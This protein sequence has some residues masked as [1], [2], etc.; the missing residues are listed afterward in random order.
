MASVLGN[1]VSVL[2]TDPELALNLLFCSKDGLKLVPGKEMTIHSEIFFH[3]A[4]TFLFL[5]FI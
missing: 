3:L 1:L 2:S 4:F 5:N